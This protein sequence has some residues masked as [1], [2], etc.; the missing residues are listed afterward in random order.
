V[1]R[2]G[3][4]VEGIFPGRPILGALPPDSAP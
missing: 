3:E 2:D 1:V 4:L